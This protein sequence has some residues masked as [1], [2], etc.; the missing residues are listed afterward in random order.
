MGRPPAKLSG[1]NAAEKLN[2]RLDSV[3]FGA[4]HQLKQAAYHG[5]LE[6]A[7]IA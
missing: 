7:G 1:G 3:W 5:A 2:R 6:L 4:L